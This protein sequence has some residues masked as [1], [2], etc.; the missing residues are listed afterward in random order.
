MQKALGSTSV[1]GTVI[2]V[3]SYSGTGSSTFF[4]YASTERISV[5]ETIW[6]EPP[7]SGVSKPVRGFVCTCSPHEPIVENSTELMRSNF[8]VVFVISI[9]VLYLYFIYKCFKVA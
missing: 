4:I 8:A 7:N 6:V 1:E 5:S 9:Q 2:P 3:D